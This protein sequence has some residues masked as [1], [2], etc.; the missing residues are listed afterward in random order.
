M[1]LEML[2]TFANQAKG[3]GVHHHPIALRMKVRHRAVFTN[4][5][6]SAFVPIKR[7]SD[8][9]RLDP[10]RFDL[11]EVEFSSRR[12]S[13]FEP[14][15]AAQ[16]VDTLFRISTQDSFCSP[17]QRSPETHLLAKTQSCCG[18]LGN[19]LEQKRRPKKRCSC[20]KLN[21]QAKMLCGVVRPHQRMGVGCAKAHDS[22]MFAQRRKNGLL[23]HK[24]PVVLTLFKGKHHVGQILCEL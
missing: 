16:S 18:P 5:F 14:Y 21:H 23:R 15:S 8:R 20:I 13:A 7:Q 19:R 17:E 11:K 1:H 2:Y 6:T 10:L 24:I 9:D 22:V 12:P 4:L 3:F